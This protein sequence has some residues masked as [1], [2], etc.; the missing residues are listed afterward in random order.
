MVFSVYIKPSEMKE[1]KKKLFFIFICFHF[2][3][4]MPHKND[5]KKMYVRVCVFVNITFPFVVVDIYNV[6]HEC[7]VCVV[8][9]FILKKNI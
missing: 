7:G 2:L 1:E 3:F 8:F 5:A 4:C 6:A 9:T